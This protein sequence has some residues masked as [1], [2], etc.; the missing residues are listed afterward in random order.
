MVILV[1]I[2]QFQLDKAEPRVTPLLLFVFG[3]QL[4]AARLARLDIDLAAVPCL[5]LQLQLE[6]VPA[7]FQLELLEQVLEGPLIRAEDLPTPTDAE[8]KAPRT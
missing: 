3:A 4:D 5:V 8:R 7:L 1:G 6:P 2:E